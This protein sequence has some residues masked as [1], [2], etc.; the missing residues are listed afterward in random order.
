MKALHERCF[1]PIHVYD[2]ATSRP[3]AVLLLIR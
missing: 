3:L 2:V 1:L